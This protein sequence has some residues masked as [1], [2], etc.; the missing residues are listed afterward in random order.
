MKEGEEDGETSA[1]MTTV[2]DVVRR[3]FFFVE[4]RAELRFSVALSL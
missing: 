2:F 4:R 1:V 3:D